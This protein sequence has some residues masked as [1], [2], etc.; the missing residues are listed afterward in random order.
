MK[1]KINVCKNCEKR[2]SG[3][4]SDCEDYHREKKAN[5]D[6]DRMVREKRDAEVRYFK[7]RQSNVPKRKDR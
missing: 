4:H 2:H 5:D 3:C 6:F 7:M 1:N